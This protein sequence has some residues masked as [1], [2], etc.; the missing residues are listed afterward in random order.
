MTSTNSYGM[1]TGFDMVDTLHYAFDTQSALGPNDD[2]HYTWL[3]RAGDLVLITG[4]GIDF[5]NH[6]PAFGTVTGISI[7][8]GGNPADSA[9]VVFSNLPAGLDLS[10]ILSN[11]ELESSAFA[12]SDSLRGTDFSDRLFGGVGN[13]IFIAGI[14]ADSYF[15]GTGKDTLNFVY[16]SAGV[17]VYL[18]YSGLDVG[19]GLGAKTFSSIEALQGTYYDDRL[20]GDTGDNSLKGLGGDD[21]LKGKG[22]N[23][24]IWGDDGNDTIRAG[25]GNDQLKGGNGDDIV[26][27]LGGMDH[28]YGDAGIDHLYGGSG[29]DFVYG[30]GD[31]DF[32][33][34]NRGDD[35]LYGGVD[36]DGIGSGNDDLRG[37]GGNDQ[38]YAGDGDDFLFGGNGDDTL[39]GG[40]GNDAMTGGAG[41]DRFVFE[42]NGSGFDRVKDFAN[43]EDILKISGFGLTFGE[44]NALSSDTASG[45]RINFGG[46]NVLFVEGF[47]KADFD[48][49]DVWI[50]G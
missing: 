21:I 30:G 43:G 42:N 36:M 11:H 3:T 29:I 18:M 40:L 50:F 23:D 22:G 13:D 37:G 25:D 12:G 41:V 20:I 31:G 35:R 15:G 19:A 24:F 45:L 49:T 7:I 39:Y 44:I 32:L 1:T 8:Y 38:L 17:S 48:A 26:F 10:T 47:L 46:G 34:G 16:A 5:N 27:G 33:R 14:G 6:P 9:N 4:S 28:L 2:T